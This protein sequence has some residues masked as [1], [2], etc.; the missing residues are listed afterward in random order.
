MRSHA[1]APLLLA[2]ALAAAPG[3]DS[4]SGTPSTQRPERDVS[5]LRDNAVPFRTDAPGGDPSDLAP[6]GRIVGGARVV[7]LGEATH[8]T[9]EFFRMKHRVLEYL[10]KEKGFTTFGIEA[11]WAE[12]ERINDYVHGAPGDPHKLLSAQKFWTWN[13]QEVLDMIEWMRRHNQDPGGAPKVSF[14]GFDMQYA[15]VAMDDVE[16]FLARVDPEGLREVREHFAC[17]RRYE[18]LPAGGSRADYTGAPASEKQ[19]C[20]AGVAA[21]HALLEAR[22]ERYVRASSAKDY[23]RALRAARIVVQNEDE[24]VNGAPV[25]DGYMAE[26]AAWLL[27]QAGPGAKMVVWAHNGHVND[28][29]V[30]MGAHLRRRF[31]A[32]FVAVAFSFDRGSFNAYVNA[33]SSALAVRPS[34]VGDAPAGTYEHEFRRLGHPRFFVDLRPLRGSPPASAAWMGGPLSMRRVGSLFSP[35]NPA[36]YLFP[37]PLP[38]WFDVVIHFADT[39]PSTLLPFVR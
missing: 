12:C 25:R 38:Q 21:V 5:W 2:L 23:E 20:R 7:G 6:L 34:T 29:D 30:L 27:E 31:G 36:S 16:A 8:G 35:I 32:D 39:T 1:A 11:T 4:P 9:R 13:T 28:V 33:P 22:R 19:L 17:F 18:D 15:R 26:N 37:T 14:H 3:C 24:Q 10:V